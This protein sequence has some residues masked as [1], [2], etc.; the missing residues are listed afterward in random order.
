[1]AYAR[2]D[3]EPGDT[4]TI[5]LTNGQIIDAGVVTMP[6]YDPENKRQEM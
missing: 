4:I 1:M 2:S 3:T 6:F 5:K